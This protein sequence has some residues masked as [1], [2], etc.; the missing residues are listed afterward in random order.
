[1]DTV[2]QRLLWFL[3]HR[4]T[5]YAAAW[6]VCTIS[7][8]LS[9]LYA[10]EAFADG[11]RG[12]G[13]AGHTTIDFGGQWVMGALLLEG[14]GRHLYHR[15]SQRHLLQRSFPYEDEVPDEQRPKKD[16]GKRDAEELMTWF[17]G[18]DRDK[19]EPANASEVLASF[20][21]PLAAAD[22][23]GGAALWTVGQEEWTAERAEIAARPRL[24]GPLYPPVNALYMAPLALVRPLTAYY[25]NQFLCLVWAMIAGL[26]VSYLTRGNIWWP[27]AATLI[28]VYPGFKGSIHLGQNAPLTLCILVWGWA[29]LARGHPIWGGMVWGLLAFK[30]VWAASF[31]LVPFLTGRPRFCLAMLGSGAALGLATVPF[32][33]IHSWL[34][35]LSVGREAAI[36]Y[37]TDQNWVFLSRDLLGIPRRWMLDFSPGTYGEQRDRLEAAIVGWSIWAVVLE[38][39][40]MLTALRWRQRRDTTGP[41]P[42][43]LFLAAWL[44][45][46]HFMYYDSLLSVLPFFLLCAEPRRYLEPILVALVSLPTKRLPAD[47][48]SYYGPSLPGEYPSPVPL[49]PAGH[50]HLIILNRMVP[51][52]LLL[53]LAV[54]HAFTPLGL[55]VSVTGYWS[56]GTREATI[57]WE[58]TTGP[59]ETA[60]KLVTT[61]GQWAERPVKLSSSLYADGQP[62]DTY[63]LI[64][65]WLW[66][67]GLWL[68]SRPT[69][70]PFETVPEPITDVILLPLDESASPAIRPA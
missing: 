69:P 3:F 9:A 4:I 66:C 23:F 16:Q 27:I 51:S 28:M 32:V 58:E 62:W 65:L 7:L 12:D 10:R 8:Y 57:Q 53:M 1:M 31:F 39:T 64:F 67:G 45:C 40:L 55:G 56:P 18:A 48:A 14:E 22:P 20:V 19:A 70:A 5:R 26:G 37:N 41:V 49:L 54:E 60:K 24:G 46:Y 52:V 36:L 63:V 43:F 25:V 35:W 61:T 47:L 42:A 2:W 38:L 11:R 17:M 33:G 21:M 59:A 34:E 6:V 29:L 44:L 68:R 50:R 13:N 30:P 15:A